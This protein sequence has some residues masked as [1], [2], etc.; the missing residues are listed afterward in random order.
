MYSAFTTVVAVHRHEHN[1]EH[2]YRMAAKT[3]E[4]LKQRGDEDYGEDD[5]GDKHKHHMATIYAFMVR[6]L[7][8]SG[9]GDTETARQVRVSGGG[10]M[11]DD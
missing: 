11:P 9:G 4:L 2:S 3:V 6:C 5:Y 8:Q 10:K 1:Y 7:L